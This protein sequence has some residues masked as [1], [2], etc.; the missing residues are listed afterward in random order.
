MADEIRN[1]GCMKNESKYV[2]KSKNINQPSHMPNIC[3]QFGN[4][5]RYKRHAF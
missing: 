4:S 3:D 5:K 2:Q 1:I